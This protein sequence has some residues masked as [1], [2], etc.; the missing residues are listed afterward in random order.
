MLS[1]RSQ[2]VT[3]PDGLSMTSSGPD[4]QK[5]LMEIFL[6]DS[7]SSL[8]SSCPPFPTVRDPCHQSSYQKRGTC[9]SAH[10]GPS[11]CNEAWHRRRTETKQGSPAPSVAT[12]AWHC[13]FLITAKIGPGVPSHLLNAGAGGRLPQG[14]TPGSPCTYCQSKAN[15]KEGSQPQR[16]Y[17]DI[18]T[19]QQDKSNYLSE[20]WDHIERKHWCST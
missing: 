3:E 1:S 9:S 16:S 8:Q 7:T 12:E 13:V 19:I 10:F 17:K 5:N 18:L 2:V 4:R 15:D 11:P 20:L 6:Q 14:S